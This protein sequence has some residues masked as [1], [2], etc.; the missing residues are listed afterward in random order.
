MPPLGCSFHPR[1]PRA[2]EVCGWESR[3][4]R[5]ML[6]ARWTRLDEADYERERALIGDL[7]TLD[8]PDYGGAAARRRRRRTAR[9]R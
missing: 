3:D 6:E 9:T 7:D 4:L 5:T 1:C 8:E 2:F